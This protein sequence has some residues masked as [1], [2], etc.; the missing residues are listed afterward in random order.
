MRSL[1]SKATKVFF[2]VVAFLSLVVVATLGVFSNLS[3][4]NKPTPKDIPTPSVSNLN[5]SVDKKVPVKK[6]FPNDKKVP[7]E[8]NVPED[9]KVPVEKNAHVDKNFP[10]ENNAPVDK[11]IPVDKTEPGTFAKNIVEDYIQRIA[12]EYI[13]GIEQDF[14]KENPQFKIHSTKSPKIFIFL[15]DLTKVKGAVIVNAANR[16]CLGG[17]GIDSAIHSAANTPGKMELSEYIKNNFPVLTEKQIVDGKNRSLFARNGDRIFTGG[18]LIT[19]P[20]NLKA[21]AIIH[22]AGPNCSRGDQFEKENSKALLQRAYK[23]CLELADKCGYSRIVFP[24]LS[25]AIFGYPIEEHPLHAYEAV[26]SF[27]ADKN[28]QN[29]SIKEVYFCIFPTDAKLIESYKKISNT[30]KSE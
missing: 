10:V 7:V 25:G 16:V 23:S 20:F 8:K 22:T 15:G 9:K 11:K 28:N 3:K 21:S 24:A 14:K 17:G 26:E 2:G 12:K 30:L 5:A 27:F 19:P 1:G 4:S 18:C 13:N 6:N 29:T